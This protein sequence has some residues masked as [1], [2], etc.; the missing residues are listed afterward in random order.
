MKRTFPKQTNSK[1]FCCAGNRNNVTTPG[2][3]R[4]SDNTVA[5]GNM[6]STELCRK[7]NGYRQDSSGQRNVGPSLR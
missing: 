7:I 4:V 5:A 2:Y 1:L 3:A 6:L